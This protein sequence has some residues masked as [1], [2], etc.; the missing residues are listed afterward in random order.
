MSAVAVRRDV[1]QAMTKRRFFNTYGSNPISC[2]ASRAVLDIIDKEDLQANAAKI[3]ARFF[4]H[5]D[6][7]RAKHD[8]IGDVRGHGLMIGIQ[9]VTDRAAKTPAPAEAARVGDLAR[10]GGIIVGRSGPHKN[11]L[12]ISPPLCLDM[13]DADD[14][15]S[16]LDDA[17]AQ[18]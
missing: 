2:A 15:A 6:R 3:S 12:R 8:V 16:V 5:F 18:L 14:V 9:L 11:V 17:F 13:T 7:L 1:A 10:D 4:D